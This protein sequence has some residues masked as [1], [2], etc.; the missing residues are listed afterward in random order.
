ETLT[1]FVLAEHLGG[2]TFESSPT[3]AGYARLLAGGRKPQQTK[4]GYIALLPYTAEHW[5]AFL[6][7]ARRGHLAEALGTE[8]RQTRNANIKTLYATVSDIPRTRTTAEWMSI[9]DALDIPATPIYGLDDLPHHPQLKATGLFQ[10][11]DHPSEGAIRYVRP[12][13]KFEAT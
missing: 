2:L 7:A 9:L 6:G 3:P 12:P 5:R 10:I 11:M 13:T 8:D 1:A 4:D